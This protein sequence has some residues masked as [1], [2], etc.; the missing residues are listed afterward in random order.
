MLQTK[1][2][3]LALIIPLICPGNVGKSSNMIHF[4]Y[5]ILP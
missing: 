5:F 4:H 2:F 1:I 3:V